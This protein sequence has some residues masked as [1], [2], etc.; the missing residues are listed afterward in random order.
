MSPP[1]H[2][3]LVI[4]TLIVPGDDGN[5]ASTFHFSLA[6]LSRVIV[7]EPNGHSAVRQV[8]LN[9][10]VRKN[11]QQAEQSSAVPDERFVASMECDVGRDFPVNV[12][13][14]PGNPILKLMTHDDVASGTEPTG[15]IYNEGCVWYSPR[16]QRDIERRYWAEWFPR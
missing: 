2:V 16:I 5:A 10:D 11:I 7:E 13:M 9:T 3:E 12:V 8:A 1:N 14:T 4:H 15:E 6:H